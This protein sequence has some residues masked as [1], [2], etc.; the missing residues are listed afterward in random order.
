MARH[1]RPRAARFGLPA[2]LGLALALAA[3]CSGGPPPV[4]PADAA[5]ANLALADLQDGRTLLVGRCGGCHRPP[6]PADH[7]AREWPVMLDEMAGRANLDLAQRHL[8]EVYLV[9]MAAR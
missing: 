9:T 8:V 3:G 5:R 1:R 6:V 4:T 2:G 7:A